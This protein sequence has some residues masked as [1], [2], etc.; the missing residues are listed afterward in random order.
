MRAEEGQDD[1]SVSGLG[2]GGGCAAMDGGCGGVVV[3][4][5]AST[6]RDCRSAS[7]RLNISIIAVMAAL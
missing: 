3:D 5:R 7:M 1:V 2:R 6:T 4:A